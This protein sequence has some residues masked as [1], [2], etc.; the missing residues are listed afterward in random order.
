MPFLLHEREEMMKAHNRVTP[1]GKEL[2]VQM[3]RLTEPII[4]ELARQGEP[5]DRCESCAFRLGTVPN[6]CPQTQMDAL[7]A[8]LEQVVFLC[9]MSPKS[10]SGNYTKIC[11]G[12]YA[13]RTKTRDTEPIKCPWEFSKE[14]E[15]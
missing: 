10:P 4:E 5:D 1:E 13:A 15:D 2:G 9:H 6:G 12:W 7:K 8:V 14:D 11:H 3:A